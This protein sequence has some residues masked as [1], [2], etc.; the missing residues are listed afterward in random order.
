[1][2]SK[3]D[4][5]SAISSNIKAQKDAERSELRRLKSEGRKK[6]A[7]NGIESEVMV[8]VKSDPPPSEYYEKFVQ[9]NFDLDDSATT[10]CN[11]VDNESALIEPK[12][13]TYELIN[14]PTSLS[15]DSS[16]QFIGT[17]VSNLAT[18][19]TEFQEILTFPTKSPPKFVSEQLDAENQEVKEGFLLGSEA[20]S[21][22]TA[23]FEELDDEYF[24]EVSVKDEDETISD[25]SDMSFTDTIEDSNDEFSGTLTDETPF[26]KL[27]EKE[28][29]ILESSSS[30]LHIREDTVEET[31]DSNIEERIL[32]L[33]N[34][35]VSE[36]KDFLISKFGYE[37]FERCLNMLE[38]IDSLVETEDDED[39]FLTEIQQLLGENSLPYLDLMYKLL[40]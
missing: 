27:I 8:F 29:T 34:E 31:S 7:F 1:M 30:E 35:D 16:D 37:S 3:K 2:F 39:E 26:N 18:L 38:S 28:I 21:T 40:T 25:V 4:V 17:D 36:I 33:M 22:F 32:S 5:S 15:T 12:S 19:I 13:T 20:I 9:P 11:N 23:E 6:N 14:S 10:I 24:E